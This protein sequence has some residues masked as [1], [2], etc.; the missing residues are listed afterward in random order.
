MIIIDKKTKAILCGCA[1]LT[2]TVIVL[3]IYAC[4]SGNDKITANFVCGALIAI[5]A[6]LFIS[7]GIYHLSGV[8]KI[9]KKKKYISQQIVKK[10]KALPIYSRNMVIV[11]ISFYLILSLFIEYDFKLMYFDRFTLYIIIALAAAVFFYLKLR[12]S[13]MLYLY[14][15]TPLVLAYHN[16]TD[17]NHFIEIMH[18]KLRPNGNDHFIAKK[19]ESIE[20]NNGIDYYSCFSKEIFIPSRSDRIHRRGYYNYIFATTYCINE[21]GTDIML[22]NDPLSYLHQNNL[23]ISK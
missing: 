17:M 6:S 1:I 2:L 10:K 16:G 7:S 4:I 5:F 3:T 22:C 9:N 12:Q 8:L 20:L 18:K 21:N 15:N 13:K 23:Y 11:C 14:K 19:C